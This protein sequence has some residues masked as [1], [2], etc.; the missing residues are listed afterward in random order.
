MTRREAIF[1][2]LLVAAIASVWVWRVQSSERSGDLAAAGAE[3]SAAYYPDDVVAYAW[4]SLEPS[5]GQLEHMT[6]VVDWFRGFEEVRELADRVD[7]ML[8]DATGSDLEGIGA[9]IGTEVSA[10]VLDLGEGRPGLAVTLEVTDR[11]EAG[12]FLAG[13]IERREADGYGSFERLAVG[14]GVIWV[15]GGPDGWMEEEAYALSAD[16]MLFA[17]DRG[18]IREVLDNVGGEEGR[19]LAASPTFLEA[20][21]AAPDQRF[22]SAY[23]DYGRMRELIGDGV[24]E[25]VCA[26]T[27]RAP[28]W[29]M[30]SAG[31]VDG[32]LV[33]DLVMPDVTGWWTETS[34]EASTEVV[35][36]GA[37]G[38]VSVG[39][40]PDVDRW[41][42]VLDGC[43]LGAL[44]PDGG[45]LELPQAGGGAGLDDDATLADALDLA[46]RVVEMGAGLD[47]EQDLFDHLGGELILVAHP[48]EREDAFVEG[49]AAVSYRPL[50]GRR[51]TGTLDALVAGLPMDLAWEDVDVGAVR[52][53]RVVSIG[54]RFS[55]GY[56][57]HGGF[58]TL[59]T[60]TEAL[61]VTVD[62]QAGSRDRIADTDKFRRTAGR[63]AY[64]P[65]L[66]AYVDIERVMD[67]VADRAMGAGKELP[68]VLVDGLGALALGVGTDGDYSRAT[69]VLSLGW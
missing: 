69:L 38:F 4:L 65:R 23:L 49:V 42:D 55:L 9:W 11:E 27:F 60:S 40:D 28:G 26:G 21:S 47:L 16:L 51:L 63:I 48:S 12:E 64:D 15:G 19:T 53:A 36:A 41:R 8:V 32:G 34:G 1:L 59:G 54:E 14:E 10:A 18:L 61:E 43:E 44:L 6:E 68:E 25:G 33:F 29:M 67:E 50:S 52:P 17:T 13:W 5:G 66:L 58:L 7:T 22:A 45:F 39:F 46:L 24:G 57:V 35:P 20:R 30:A 31:W 62:V 2:A 3:A 56:M 37:L